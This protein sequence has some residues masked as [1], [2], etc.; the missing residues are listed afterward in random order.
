MRNNFEA[1]TKMSL[2]FA[3]FFAFCLQPSKAFTQHFV[4]NLPEQVRFTV[5]L[6]D[7]HLSSAFFGKSQILTDCFDEYWLET[8]SGE[9]V[10]KT[11]ES[12]DKVISVKREKNRL[13]LDCSNE[14]I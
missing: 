2:A 1:S 8:E 9:I 3:V 11:D 10:V 7:G 12:Q 6:K 14:L 13:V 4:F 5:N